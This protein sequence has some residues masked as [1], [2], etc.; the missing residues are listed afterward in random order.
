MAIVIW[1]SKGPYDIGGTDFLKNTLITKVVL[2]LL[3][4]YIWE[5]TGCKKKKR[6]REK[7]CHD[8]SLH[9]LHLSLSLSETEDNYILCKHNNSFTYCLSSLLPRVFCNTSIFQ[10]EDKFVD[11]N[12]ERLY[13][14][15][16]VT[17]SSKVKGIIFTKPS[18]LN[19]TAGISLLV[20]RSYIKQPSTVSYF[21][22]SKTR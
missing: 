14:V 8:A 22:F 7:W 17:F 6:E 15:C 3:P 11:N 19:H 12:W 9:L 1:V 2:F 20:L 10:I 5:S 21:R 16:P 18:L 13:L 4:S